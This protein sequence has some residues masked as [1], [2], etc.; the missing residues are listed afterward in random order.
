MGYYEIRE[1]AAKDLQ[2]L[3]TQR[4]YLTQEE[5]DRLEAQMVAKYGLSRK[6]MRELIQ[7]GIAAGLVRL[8]APSV[9]EA[10]RKKADEKS[11]VIPPHEMEE[12]E[13]RLKAKPAKK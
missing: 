5:I 1:A 6:I 11:K 13:K 10:E 4:P 12:V 9:V 7:S 8:A 2:L 3:Y